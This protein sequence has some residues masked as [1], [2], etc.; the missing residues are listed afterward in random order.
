[1]TFEYISKEY[2]L[3]LASA[4]PRRKMLLRQIGLPFR[5]KACNIHE[6]DIDGRPSDIVCILA[7]QKATAAY[8]KLPNNWILGADTIVV[9][10]E[11]I[12]GKPI[13]HE[14]ARSML[15]LLSD[16]EHEVITG[17]SMPLL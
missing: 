8:S 14:E 16:R 5:S 1:M 17:F 9:L 2:P 11:A 7:E 13:D 15:S 3:I 4:S 10:E 12:L 6:Q